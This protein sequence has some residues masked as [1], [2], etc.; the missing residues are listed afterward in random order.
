MLGGDVGVLHLVG[1]GLGRLQ[2][3]LGLAG[4]AH[5]G[6]AVDGA[7]VLQPLRQFGAEGGRAGADPL[8]DGHGE[9]AVLVQQGDGEML[10][11]HLG[12]PALHGGL[13]SGGQRLL[14]LEREPFQLH[15]HVLLMPAA[16]R[17]ASR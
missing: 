7:E 13:L 2:R 3:R 17:D 9:A 11:L 10:G 4:E 16:R 12:V 1:L 6:V 15:G 8:Q 5:L 14:G